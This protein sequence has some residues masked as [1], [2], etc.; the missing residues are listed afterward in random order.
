MKTFV[1]LGCAA[2]NF[3]K[4]AL[5]SV[6]AITVSS[7]WLLQT[8]FADPQR[9]FR[10]DGLTKNRALQGSD[11][12]ERVMKNQF[13]CLVALGAFGCA[14]PL[15]SETAQTNVQLCLAAQ[16]TVGAADGCADLR[17]A[18]RAKLGA[19]MEGRTLDAPRSAATSPSSISRS[20]KARYLLC[21]DEARN[22]LSAIE[23]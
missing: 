13:A 3:T 5:G 19:C 4:M 15:L 20:Y 18:Y 11:I 10:G 7:R 6:P 16:T 21:A 12:L 22:S 14:G 17:T 1:F 2:G 9:A 8:G 23:N